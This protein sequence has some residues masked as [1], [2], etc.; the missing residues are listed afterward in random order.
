MNSIFFKYIV[1]KYISLIWIGTFICFKN[2]VQNY[3]ILNKMQ[4]EN[5]IL[6]DRFFKFFIII[7]NLNTTFNILHKVCGYSTFE[8][9]KR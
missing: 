3:K 4:N 7:L 1:Q 8:I 6:S 9:T 2:I 5:Y